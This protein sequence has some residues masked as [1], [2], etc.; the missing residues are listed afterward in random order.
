MIAS[1]C[2]SG[3]IAAREIDA[4]LRH[5]QTLCRR[6]DEFVVFLPDKEVSLRRER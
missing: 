2:E 4:N 5:G 6:V 3:V 1:T